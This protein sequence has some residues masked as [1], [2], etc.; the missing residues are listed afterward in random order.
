MHRGRDQPPKIMHD[1]FGHRVRPGRLACL[2]DAFIEIGFRAGPIIE[3]ILAATE[4]KIAGRTVRVRQGRTR[5]QDVERGITAEDFVLAPIFVRSGGS[6]TRRV[7]RSIS[8]QRKPPISRARAPV[9]ISKRMMS[10]Y[11]SSRSA[12]QMSRS[13]ALVIKRL[14]SISSRR[15]APSTGLLSSKPSRMHHAKKLDSV[16]CT[17]LV[18]RRISF[19]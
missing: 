18:V 12:D 19:Q 3:A 13:S 14:R 9:R 17:R 15:S 1:P 5:A 16:D 7:V 11:G 8:L 4:Y 2:I 6:V 10:P